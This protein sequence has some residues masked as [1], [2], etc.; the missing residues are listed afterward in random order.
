MQPARHQQPAAL[1]LPGYNVYSPS[2]PK[3]LHTTIG[4]IGRAIDD[5]ARYEPLRRWAGW[6]ASKAPAK[7]YLRQAKSIYDDVVRNRWRYVKNPHGTEAVVGTG[8]AAWK[9]TLGAGAPAGARGFGDCGEITAALGAALKAAGFPVRM[10]TISKPNSGQLFEHIYPIADI[11]RVG[12]VAFDAV[13]YPVH[14][15]GWQAPA[16]RKAVWS[17]TG[18][19]VGKS[20]R[21]GR[22]LAQMFRGLSGDTDTDREDLKMYAFP[23]HGLETVGLAGYEGARNLRPWNED[24]LK[25]FGVHA[26]S[27]GTISGENIPNILMEYDETDV[28]D[29]LGRVRTKMLE[30]APDDY[31]HAVEHG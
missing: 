10:V 4:I 9:I 7:D 20:G 6:A 14:G 3:I 16:G 30:L 19:I 12:W 21:F 2:G 17:T 28:V 26:A 5:G 23:D 29:G 1:N 24:V 27:M 22:S 11:P 18:K 13:G 25:G 15:L 8:E 31:N